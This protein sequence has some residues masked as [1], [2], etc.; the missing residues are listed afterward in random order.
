MGKVNVVGSTSVIVKVPFNS[1]LAAPLIVTA[2]PLVSAGLGAAYNTIVTT[3]P[4][5]VIDDTVDVGPVIPNAACVRLVFVVANGV[6]DRLLPVVV[7]H[8]PVQVYTLRGELG[9]VV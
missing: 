2:W 1:T 9:L 5:R 6:A 3:L 4:V 7:A 8:V